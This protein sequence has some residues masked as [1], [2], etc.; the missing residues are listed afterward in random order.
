MVKTVETLCLWTRGTHKKSIQVSDFDHDRQVNS[1]AELTFGVSNK[2]GMYNYFFLPGDKIE[3]YYGIGQI[4]NVPQFTGYPVSVS[5][6]TIKKVTCVDYLACA[7]NEWVKLDDYTNYDGYL[8]SAAIASLISGLNGTPLT[9]GKSGVETERVITDTDDIRYPEYAD[10]LSVIQDINDLCW[11]ES[12]ASNSYH[13]LPYF[14]Y[15][16]GTTFFHKKQTDIT[17]ATPVM[18]IAYA[19]NLLS[20]DPEYTMDYTC[21][22][23]TYIG[24]EY[25]DAA[26]NTRRY[27][28]TH[29]DA[30]NLANMRLF[31]VVKE[32][33][34][35]PSDGD[36]VAAAE[37]YVQANKYI[38]VKSSLKHT[39]GMYLTPGVSVIEIENSR[40]GIS[41]NNLVVG[42][43]V[44]MSA[45]V[46]DVNIDLAQRKSVLTDFF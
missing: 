4:P 42:V 38:T 3:F 14:F 16:N 32:D 2:S 24:G 15:V 19:D 12:Y 36:C 10:K 41:G 5:G 1:A 39:D 20:S 37:R 30:T 31:H 34:K 22:R 35:L 18:S 28:G 17:A 11:D 6:S 46:V 23:C 43:N 26:G 21:N 25:K 44:S 45:G 29:T 27:E 8:A 9:V 33:K 13:P 7:K 40:Y